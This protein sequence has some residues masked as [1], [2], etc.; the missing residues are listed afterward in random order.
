MRH[1]EILSIFET[2]PNEDV[3]KLEN[4]RKNT[5]SYFGVRDFYEVT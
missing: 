5:F 3:K 1:K 2:E 4:G